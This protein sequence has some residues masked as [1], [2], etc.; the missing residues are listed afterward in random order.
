[1]FRPYM[2]I[3]RFFPPPLRFRYI[4]CDVE[5]SHPTII[6][7]C[8]CIGEYYSTLIY[9]CI[10]IVSLLVGGGF[11][12]GVSAGCQPPLLQGVAV[13]RLSMVGLAG[14]VW[15]VWRHPCVSL[16]VVVPAPRLVCVLCALSAVSLRLCAAIPYCWTVVCLLCSPGRCVGR[17]NLLGYCWLLLWWVAL[18]ITVCHWVYII[19]LHCRYVLKH[20]Y[21]RFHVSYVGAALWLLF[22]G[23]MYALFGVIGRPC[24]G[25]R[26]VVW[27][28]RERLGN[29]RV[30][31]VGVVYGWWGF[32]SES[33]IL[34]GDMECSSF[35]WLFLENSV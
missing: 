10:Y 16:S 11:I 29:C 17:G 12:L 32:S 5:I 9:I 24:W 13:T 25:G 15:H 28:L 30:G 8:L 19:L 7:V 33:K 23:C 6:L 2:A 3:I 26:Q 31:G 20:L 18:Y 34:F 21:C 4:N 1:M 27:P 22:P 14:T 35:R